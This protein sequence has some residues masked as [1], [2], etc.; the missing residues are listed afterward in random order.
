MLRTVK[1]VGTVEKATGLSSSN[2]SIF[3]QNPSDLDQKKR[4]SDSIVWGSYRNPGGGPLPLLAEPHRCSKILAVQEQQEGMCAHMPT[5]GRHDWLVE[6]GTAVCKMLVRGWLRIDA[7][8][9][10]GVPMLG[11]LKNAGRWPWKFPGPSYQ[12]LDLTASQENS[13]ITSPK[14]EARVCHNTCYEMH[15]AESALEARSAFKCCDSTATQ[16]L[17]TSTPYSA[18]IP[19]KNHDLAVF[20]SPLRV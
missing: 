12:M 15:Q 3:Y 6:S 13:F 17:V 19:E 18:L 11:V 5:S 16:M 8:T 10:L 7:R 20:Q 14:L 9:G 2:L 1:H 4:G